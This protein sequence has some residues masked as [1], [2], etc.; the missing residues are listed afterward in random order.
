MTDIAQYWRTHFP[1]AAPV[2]WALRESFPDRWVRFHSLPG[3]RRYPEGKKDRAIVVERACAL[4][5]A[6]LGE[7]GPYYLLAN[8][9]A[10]DDALPFAVT[11]DWTYHTAQLTQAFSCPEDAEDDA[12]IIVVFTGQ[13]ETLDRHF[14]RAVLGIAEDRSARC[15]WVSPN[16]PVVFAPY[17]GG[18]DLITAKP[19]QATALKQSFKRWTSKHPEGL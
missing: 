18:F 3:S 7:D 6:L 15:V 10:P 1:G 14:E 13:T 5:K 17:D 11:P 19:Q 8:V 9:Y 4:A 2:G 12:S 16:K